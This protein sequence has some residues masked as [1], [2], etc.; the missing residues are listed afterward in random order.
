M[1]RIDDAKEV[2]PGLRL[3]RS[4]GVELRWPGGGSQAEGECPWC[5]KLKFRVNPPTGEWACFGCGE[6]GNAQQFLRKLHA[7]GTVP[8][9][10]AAAL[11]GSRGLFRV[12][13]LEDWGLVVSP[14]TGE[15]LVPGYGTG[16]KVDQLYRYTDPRPPLKRLLL[17]APEYLNKEGEAVGV[18]MF[19]VNLY[20]P[21]KPRVFLCEGPWDA[22]I[23]WE[24]LRAGKMLGD[25]N[26]LAVPG[27]GVFKESWLKLFFGKDVTLF[28]DSDHPAK[29]P[30][31][32]AEVGL[33]GFRGARRTTYALAGVAR[34]VGY[35]NWGGKGEGFDPARPSGFD[36][37]DFLKAGETPP[38][39]AALLERLLGMVAP[40]PESWYEEARATRELTPID[41]HSW[42]EVERT[43]RKAM[44]WRRSLGDVLATMLAVAISTDLVGD[45]LFLQVIGDAGCLHGDTPIYDPVTG[46]TLSVR[47]RWAKGEGFHVWS[48]AGDGSVVVAYALP[49]KRF[50]V[51]PMYKVTFRSGR[52]VTVTAEHRFWAGDEYLSVR[53]VLNALRE[54]GVCRLPSISGLDLSTQPGGDQRSTRTIRDSLECCCAC[55]CPCGER[56]R[57]GAS[58][59]LGSLPLLAGAPVRSSP[60][61]RGVQD[62][63][64]KRILQPRA[65]LATQGFQGL[66][67]IPDAYESAVPPHERTWPRFLACTRVDGHTHWRILPY[68]TCRGSSASF[69]GITSSDA[70]QSVRI[71]GC[72]FIRK[73]ETLRRSS[74]W[75]GSSVRPDRCSESLQPLPRQEVP[76]SFVPRVKGKRLTLPIVGEWD[77]VV[78][79]ESVGN[80]PYYDF[81]VP[82]TNNYWAEGVFHHNSGKTRFCDAL[83][84][85]RTCY[86]LE[87]ITGFHSGWKDG[88]GEDFS[89][90]ARINH[91]TLITPEGDVMMSSPRFAEIMSQQRRIF[92][93]TSGASYKNRKEDIRYTGLRTPW[94]MAGT[95][96][97]L[98]ESD[99]SRLGD[100]FLRVR[101]NDPGDEEKRNILRRVGQT[102]WDAAETLAN[103][104]P[105]GQMDVRFAAAYR[106]TG[107]YVDHLRKTAGESLAAV[108]AD[109][110]ELIEYCATLAEFTADFR[111]RPS[112]DVRKDVEHHK[113]LPSRLMFQFVKL[114]RCLAAVLNR[115]T[116]DG[117][118]TRI[119][120]KV[121]VDTTWPRSLRYGKHLYAGRGAGVTTN[122]LAAYTGDTDEKV[123]ALLRFLR[124]IGVARPFEFDANGQPLGRKRW[125]LTRRSEDLYRRVIGDAAR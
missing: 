97:L 68:G 86:P 98:D 84:V 64:G 56:P 49:P 54:Y 28:Y 104:K 73:T 3:V 67:S 18:A 21:K 59:S 122:S 75:L 89:L 96:A 119:T 120:T 34:S 30:G 95:P 22:M 121:A 32:G 102:A 65:P 114:S 113:E 91:K 23:L 50:T 46:T 36:V 20:D 80:A 27:A 78:K 15:W 29:H 76:A 24:S 69:V 61:R 25:V 105:E 48:K 7:T 74:P 103:G 55:F 33:A 53:H 79:I 26:V 60:W 88:S 11:A 106:T 2:P 83:L 45:Q 116:V 111:A 9:R 101:I 47:D 94:V 70:I 17:A 77:A 10:E 63:T 108:T 107:G 58:I 118:V 43:W 87:H 112:G 66:A 52:S 51:E 62:G 38:E 31:T 42:A 99:Q 40:V 14:L 44:R 93:G 5:G 110:A 71:S 92:D 124:G 85:S 81:H 125:R 100:R 37:R 39:R 123:R 19:G 35:L 12:K 1:P 115:P 90:L 117:E 41:C 57:T 13:T 72:T 109:P 8:E 16:G 4:F 82:E 6:R